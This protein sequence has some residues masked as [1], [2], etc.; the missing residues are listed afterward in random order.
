DVLRPREPWPQTSA[1]IAAREASRM[2]E[3]QVSG[4]DD[5]DLVWRDAGLGERVI[6]VALALH[7]IELVELPVL[8]VSK[9]RVD[10]HRPR[11]AHDQRTHGE[12]DP[13]AVVG[14]RGL[15][16]EHLGHDTEH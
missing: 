16:P 10:D 4:E 8:F 13:V 3:M 2:V 11:A 12:R 14:R 5:V 1:W 15:R 9:T 7:R 6:E